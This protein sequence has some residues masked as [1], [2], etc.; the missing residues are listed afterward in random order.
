M[1]LL[2]ISPIVAG[3]ITAYVLPLWIKK[4]RHIGLMGKDVHKI[5]HPL[6]PESG[7]IPVIFG[8]FV[9]ASLLPFDPLFYG[10]LISCF[11]GIMDDFLGWKQGLA[12]PFRMI[13]VILGWIPFIINLD[14]PIHLSLFI[15]LILSFQTLSFNFLAGY[16]GLEAGQGI[17]ILIGLSIIFLLSGQ[18]EL[19]LLAFLGIIPLSIFLGFNVF[20]ARIFPGDSLT[21]FTGALIGGLLVL[22]QLWLESIFILGLYGIEV[23]LKLRGRLK[24]ESF[25]KINEDGTLRVPYSK[26]YGIEHAII[27]CFKNPRETQVVMAIWFIQIIHS[28]LGVLTYYFF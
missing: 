25:A 13:I 28:L 10:I 23:I 27:L 17:I 20:P 11:A 8:F 7:G 4:A 19:M 18:Q 9:S 1:W 22:G 21:Y 15:G 3:L 2:W 12:A 14:F 26:I 24:K 16:N 5:G 6:I